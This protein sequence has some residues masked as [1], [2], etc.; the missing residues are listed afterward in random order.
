MK[1]LF[2]GAV[3]ASATAV[4]FASCGTTSN[5][6]K[7]DFDA[8][9]QSGDYDTC[10]EVVESRDSG[11]I[12]NGL[13]ASMLHYMKKDYAS[14]GRRL[15]ETQSEMQSVSKDM[16][17]A[18]TMEA[19]LIGENTVTYSGATYER[20][21]AYS[22][23]AVDS[24]KMGNISN[25]VGVMNDYTGNYKEEISD[26][27]AQQNEIARSSEGVMNDPK[28]V[29]A[30]EALS[31]AGLPVNL[32]KFT[33]NAPAASTAPVYEASPF[34]SYLG[35]L[36]YA[37]NG[38]SIH[39]NDF[40][41]VLKS[42]NS[43]V[44]VSKDLAIPAGKGRLDV[45]ALADTIGK[46]SDGGKLEQVGVLGNVILNFKIAYPVFEKQNHSV[47]VSKV[48]LSNG[49]SQSFIL[50]EN[51]DDA[52]RNDVEQKA[53]GAYNRS[54]F[55]NL[56]KNSAAVVAGVASLGKAQDAVNKASN[57]IQVKAA[58][59][60]YEVAVTTV[61]AS[62]TEVVDAEKADIRQASYFPRTASAAGFTVEPGT[63]TV[64]V[65]YSNGANDVIENVA[66]AAGKPTVVISEMLK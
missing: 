27:I 44:D 39:A 50:I 41:T 26:L 52:V 14:S 56:T 35:T 32:G 63:Y 9:Y 17:A 25:A 65:E 19:A 36:A 20:I 12:L 6:S 7:A 10:I 37:A 57:P 1:K 48:T 54:L 24:F 28:V 22:M 23:K 66:V 30:S 34:L 62:L 55:R 59:K 45:V 2:K 18:K 58:E 46:R 33:S 29:Q 21:L 3:V 13:D 47:E 60:A 51:F 11:S 8:A 16:T 61:N 38:D 43:K 31:K 5:A 40:A 4:L 64:T 49:D 42:T 15:T 53:R